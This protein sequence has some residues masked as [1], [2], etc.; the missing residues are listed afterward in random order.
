[1][2]TRTSVILAG[3]GAVVLALG[4]VYGSGPAGQT[5]QAAQ[6]RLMFP[7]L[8]AK[9]ADAARVEIT[10]KGSTLTFD[11]GG[12][13]DP[14]GW[15]I[16]TRG[17]YPAQAGKVHGL[18]ASL[19]GLRLDE[20]RTADPALYPRLGVEDPA[21][22]GADST[23]VRV[24]DAKGGVIAALIVGHARA[25]VSGNADTL[26][27]RRPGEAQSWLA[28]G[29][30][31]PTTDPGDW[32]DT[33]VVNILADKITG[34]MVTRGADT[35]QFARSG[36]RMTLS[37]PADHPKL[38]DFKVD[39]VGDALA[40][41]TLQDV[42]RAPAPGKPLGRAVLTTQ[43]GLVVTVDVSKDGDKLWVSLSAS[44]KDAAALNKKVK[45]WAYRIGSW[46]E[47]SLVPT[48][49]DLEAAQPAPAKPTTA[50]TAAPVSTGAP[51]PAPK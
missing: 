21:G 39:Q 24:L 37:A 19:T 4:I 6:G 30:L 45:G 26:Y 46:K 16:A 7:D 28:D 22:K 17:G 47:Q 50:S 51:V 38:D 3:I 32:I 31:A 29:K 18:L 25:A 12:K 15:G 1:M 35:L 33:T 14:A 36:A 8:V 34:D 27:V 5:Q 40:N 44:G 11:R 43:D 13:D 42:Q 2:R 48:L 23:L 41:L 9:L 20:P 10:H 49:A